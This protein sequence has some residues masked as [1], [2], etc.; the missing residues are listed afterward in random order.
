[1]LNGEVVW[2]ASDWSLSNG[3]ASQQTKKAWHQEGS[4]PGYLCSV[5]KLVKQLTLKIHFQLNSTVSPTWG[6]MN[7]GY[8][9]TIHA[10]FSRKW[11]YI[12]CLFLMQVQQSFW[13]VHFKT[14][15]CNSKT[16][17]L[18]KYISNVSSTGCIDAVNQGNW[19]LSIKL[20]V[21]AFVIVDKNY[22][23]AKALAYSFSDSKI[24]GSLL[25][26]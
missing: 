9:E 17:Q 12:S 2:Q 22:K 23:Y 16:Y 20:R 15:D 25:C 13:K 11:K 3:W 24:Q 6:T 8:L 14:T 10:M 7:T 5:S 18:W 1:M 19:S 4:N 26:K 21:D